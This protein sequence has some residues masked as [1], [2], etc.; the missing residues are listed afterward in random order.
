MWLAEKTDFFSTTGVR[1]AAGQSGN[2]AGNQFEVQIRY[3]IIPKL[4]RAQ[5]NGVY[6]AKG[7]FLRTAPNAPNT[8]NTKY[9]ATAL[10]AQF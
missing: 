9:I 2:F 5:L 1:D 10:T 3:W 4:L 8:G 6:L 7:E